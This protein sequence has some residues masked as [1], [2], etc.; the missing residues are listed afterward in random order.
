MVRSKPGVPG[1]SVSKEPACSA[2]EAGSIPGSGRSPGGGNGSPRQCSCLEDPVDR[3]PGGLSPWGCRVGH[4]GGDWPRMY[5]C[6]ASEPGLPHKPVFTRQRRKRK[7]TSVRSKRPVFS[8]AGHSWVRRRSS[9]QHGHQRW[10]LRNVGA[11]AKH[12]DEAHTT[13]RLLCAAEAFEY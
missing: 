9:P 5:A 4:G 7:E 11:T 12:T 2:G 3:E 10:G 13:K 1:G 6:T 8:E